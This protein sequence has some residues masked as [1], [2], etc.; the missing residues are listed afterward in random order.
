M[1]LNPLYSNSDLN[2][3]SHCYIKHL[4]DG[5]VTRFD[6]MTTQVKFSVRNV[7]R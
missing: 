5:E 1:A 3:I 6:N 4:S 2:Q 7:R